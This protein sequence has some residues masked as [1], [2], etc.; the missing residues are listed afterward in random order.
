[1]DAMQKTIKG[2]IAMIEKDGAEIAK[3]RRR[4]AMAV[5]RLRKMVDDRAVTGGT[6][7]LLIGVIELLE[8]KGETR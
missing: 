2:L 8:G 4:R 1:M 7:G 3:M 5:T 6:L